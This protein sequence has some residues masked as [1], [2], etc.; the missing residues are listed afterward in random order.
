[1]PSPGE[2]ARTHAQMNEQL[3]NIMHPV[4][5]SYSMGGE[6]VRIKLVECLK[7]P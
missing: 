6:G 4:P 7:V 3:E 1:M 2:H 5:R